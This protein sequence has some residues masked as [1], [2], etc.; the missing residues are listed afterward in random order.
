MNQGNRS[1]AMHTGGCR[2]SA[3]RYEL[4]VKPRRSGE[5]HCEACREA[6]ATGYIPFSG[7][8]GRPARV[9]DLA[10]ANDTRTIYEGNLLDPCFIRRKITVFTRDR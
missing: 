4:H 5:R 8:A 6:S 7:I 10:A 2:R 9:V 3:A 1:N